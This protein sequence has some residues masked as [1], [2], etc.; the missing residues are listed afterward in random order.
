MNWKAF[1]CALFLSSVYLIGDSVS[2]Q[3]GISVESIAVGGLVPS[4][5]T[6]IVIA[7]EVLRI[8]N[9]VVIDYDFRNDTDQD[10]TTEV[11]IPLPPYGIQGHWDEIELS[12]HSFQNIQTWVDGKPLTIRT[13][14]KA[15]LK[16]KDVTSILEADHIDIPSF[17]HLERVS[18]GMVASM[19]PDY[20]RLPSAE[21]QRL[22][23]AGIL[24]ET[25]Y[26]FY[27]VHLQYHWT[28]T[29]PAHSMVHIRQEYGL[30]S[31]YIMDL[32]PA[33]VRDSLAPSSTDRSTYTND[34]QAQ[35]EMLAGFC[36]DRPFLTTL[37]SQF[38]ES[39]FQAKSLYEYQVPGVHG[40]AAERISI[41]PTWVDFNLTS[42]NVWKRPIEDFSLIVERPQPESDRRTLISFCAPAN[43]NME[44]LDTDNLQVHLTNFVPASE[45]HIG[46]FE[47]P[48]AKA[49]H[50]AAKK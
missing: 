5:E 38:R 32:L 2:A 42:A 40:R 9:G 29:F 4:G 30:A 47:V 27:T 19:P 1:S 50:P 34:E 28:Q 49:A 14:A 46:F 7:K 43:G 44:K 3:D 48:L 23:E 6:Q 21:K 31:G 17:G 24:H 13:E 33:A 8:G 41:S 37:A 20:A 10:V 25:G 11:A 39:D 22:Q 35:V 18:N 12:R 15:F 26:S 45:L 36:A 16:G